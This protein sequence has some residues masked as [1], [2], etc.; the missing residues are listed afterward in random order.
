MAEDAA[1]AAEQAHSMATLSSSEAEL[2]M[3]LSSGS[4]VEGMVGRP[5][6]SSASGSSSSGV[7]GVKKEVKP[8]RTFA[9]ELFA[10]R[11]GASELGLRQP[12]SM[13]VVS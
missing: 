10:R 4:V 13:E 6:A 2:S 11:A 5:G 1:E 12:V 3:E 7:A 9:R 8:K